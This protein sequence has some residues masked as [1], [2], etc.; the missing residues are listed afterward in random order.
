LGEDLQAN[1]FVATEDALAAGLLQRLGIAWRPRLARTVSAE[2]AW[3][4]TAALV[5]QGEVSP[6]RGLEPNTIATLLAQPHINDIVAMRPDP[7]STTSTAGLLPI[8]LR[9]AMLRELADAA[10]QIAASAP[11]ADLIALLR[12]AEL[13][14]LVT[15]APLTPTW[16]R[17]LDRVAAGITG[18]ATIRQYLEGLTGFDIPATT[19]LGDFRRSLAHLQGLDSETLQYLMQGTLDLSS[20]RLDAWIT[21]FA[22]KRLAAMAAGGGNGSYVGAYGWVE[23]LKPAPAMTPVNVLPANEPGPLFTRA[24]DSGFIQ[25]PS[26][27]H[28]AAAALLRNAH[29]GAANAPQASS[30]FAISLTSRRVR[31][32]ERLLDGIRQ[33]QKLGALLGYRVERSLH[34]LGFD[35]V[36]PR[37]RKL[38]PLDVPV[39]ENSTTPMEAIAANNV[40]DGQA[41]SQMWQDNPGHV[42]DHMQP[43]D[44]GV[45]PLSPDQLKSI[46][47]ELDAL[48]DAVDGLSDALTAETAYQVARGNTSR[49]ASTLASIA[50]GDAPPPELE[51]ARTP[52]SGTALTHRLVVLFSG[53]PAVNPGW[54]ATNSS[55]R[56]S[57]EPMLNAWASRL[58]GNG[59]KL[60]C[61]IE[62]LDDSGAVAETR[63][64]PL[65]ALGVG[66]LDMVYGVEA[67]AGETAPGVTPSE[68]EQ[69]VLYQAQRVSGGFAPGSRLRLQHARP[70]DLAGGEI[71]LFDA[72]E[73]ARALRRLLARVRGLVPEDLNPPERAPNGTLDLA[74]LEARVVRAENGLNAAHVRLTSLAAN[75]AT[76]AETFRGAVLQLGGYG[77]G[78]AVPTTV[79]GESPQA[80]ATL[81][82]QAKALMKT[83]GSRLE[84][85]TALRALPAAAEPQARLGQLID[86]M[87]AVFGQEFAVLP[88]F[89]CDA[90]A[91]TELT[92]A[93]AASKQTQAGD[94]L[95]ANTWLARYAR[96]RDGVAG[97]NACLRGAEVLG[98][99]ERV[100]LS[101]AQLPFVAG[102]KW[103]GLAPDQGQDLPAGKLSLVVQAGAPVAVAQ[104]LSGVLADEWT[105]TVP[106]SRETTALTFQF[107]PPDACAPQNI[108]VAVPPVP[109]TDWTIET[110]LKVLEETLD[111]TK[112][113]TV[114][115]ETLGEAAQYLP[116]LY[117]AFN[118][119]DDAVSTDFAPLTR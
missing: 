74:E 103:V 107:D 21:S 115:P 56:A 33:G 106:N 22:T 25:A 16:Q 91:V 61:T 82:A 85:G 76:T 24:S 77:V 105:E 32:A 19:S 118:A 60:R 57:S 48:V 30:P 116:A 12:D 44:P 11:G 31:E 64:F 39:L 42:Q 9:H 52:R 15:D 8:L 36:V 79:A 67:E 83:S 101:V 86:R 35:A 94:A 2:A 78:P 63:G 87:R 7:A 62:R 6:W 72:L 34:D 59:T 75:T 104:P 102:E 110:L 93:L 58:L 80:V 46:G 92:A 41:L 17:Q 66:A 18:T 28:A 40:V 47:R 100:R 3:P 114:D 71:T 1:G 38:A 4:V 43:T 68:V 50:Q 97:A 65:S 49:I 89:S 10:A 37:L 54:L 117:L 90:P 13:V 81:V 108:L 73:Q 111:L 98:T 53:A 119:R 20:H 95:A 55:I 88:R 5:Q 27:T 29:L 45:P 14:D 113:R 70:A 26:L 99:G 69:F 109:G 23:N 51:V 112:L 84:R 96:V